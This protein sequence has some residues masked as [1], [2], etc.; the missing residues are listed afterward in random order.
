MKGAFFQK[1]LEWQID[2]V[3]EAWAQGDVIKGEL[4]VKNLGDS[5]IDLARAGVRLSYADIKKVHSRNELAF[6]QEAEILF[7]T[8]TTIAPQE[9]K[10]L[11]IQF[12]LPINCPVTDKKASYYITYGLTALESNLQVHV[13]PRKLFTE[14]TKLLETFQRFK[15]KDIK[16]S[17]GAVEFKMVPPT[18]REYAHVEALHLEQSLEG[19]QLKLEFTFKVKI[20]DPNS[21]TTKVAKDE[22]HLTKVLTPREYSLGRDMINQDGIL[23]AL[24]E[25]LGQIKMKGL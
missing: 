9:S 22:R 4:R 25:V 17:K 21:V 16:A 8:G 11:P 23:K 5:P 18:S 7:P 10:T 13:G 12:P 6:K 2:V 24:E 20:L 15:P 19:D 3:G 14:I 1:P